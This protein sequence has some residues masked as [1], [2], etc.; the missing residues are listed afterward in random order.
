MAKA[1]A[2]CRCCEFESVKAAFTVFSN[3]RTMR[4]NWRESNAWV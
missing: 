3:A 2:I 1:H 4:Y